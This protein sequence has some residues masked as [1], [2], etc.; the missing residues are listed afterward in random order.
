MHSIHTH[1]GL[2]DATS[3]RILKPLA[4]GPQGRLDGLGRWVCA[5][6]RSTASVQ[7]SSHTRAQ[8]HSVDLR[9]ATGTLSESSRGS[10]VCPCRHLLAAALSCL[11]LG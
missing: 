6:M 2:R 10:S 1:L 11:V 4:A 3:R 7:R 8:P 9:V 5:A